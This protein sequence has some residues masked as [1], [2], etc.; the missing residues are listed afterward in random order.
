MAFSVVAVAA[1]RNRRLLTVALAF[2]GLIAALLSLGPTF[3]P[4]HANG[5]PLPYWWLFDNFPVFRS[6]RVPARLGGLVDLVIVI[7]AGIGLAW[8]WDR[9][10]TSPRFAGVSQ[11]PAFA[12]LTMVIVATFIVADLWTG[13]TPLEPVN[14]GDEAGAAAEWLS[15]QPEGPVMEFPAESVFADPAAASVRRHYGETMYWSTR[16]CKP[17]INGN[18]G[19]IPR[20][21]SDFIERFVGE[22]AR[23]DG[24]LTPRISHVNEETVQLLDQ[25]GV[26]Y[27]VFHREQYRQEDWP[28]VAAKLAI[29][30]ERGTLS[31][32]GD[33]GDASIYVLNPTAPGE[34]A[35]QVSIFAP[36]LLTARE[37]WS[38]WVAVESVTGTPRVLSLTRPSQLEITWYDNDGRLLWRDAKRLPLPVVLDEPRLLCSARECLT[39]RPFTDLSY[40]P[41]PDPFQSW[42]PTEEGHYI[43]RLRLSGDRSLE[44]KVD[45]DVV[46]DASEVSERANEDVYRW[47]ECLDSS[48]NPVNDPGARPFTLSPPSVTLVNNTAVVDIA[49]TP[50]DDEEVR[51]WFILAPPGAA[52]PWNEAVYQSQVQQKLLPASD[53]TAFEWTVDIASDV[54]PGI[55]GLTV[56]FHRRGPSGWEHAIGGDI[57]LAPIVVAEDGTLRWAGPIRARL[58]HQPVPLVPGSARALELEVYGMSNRVSCTATWRLFAGDRVVASGN[59]GLCASPEVALPPG[60]SSG[61]YRLRIDLFAVHDDEL[62]LSDAVSVPVAVTDDAAD[63][64]PS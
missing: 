63:S 3:G 21:Y 47:A 31:P 23:P 29:L 32:A 44:C 27:L 28:A 41:P 34:E 62:I 60:V 6:M 38:P 15:T 61:T 2:V 36:T 50:R 45:L 51:G 14:R 33:H 25:I 57:E 30:V 13:G 8:T 1:S 4:R 7:L 64:G 37:P 9:I 48:R 56:W 49:V 24:S 18:S 16:H 58:A 59:G 42:S 26:R 22:V 17:L 5:L 52:E 19:F 12:V 11:Q 35:P 39:S 54:E 43:V 55:Y 20:A 53:S 46:A 40:L 10:K